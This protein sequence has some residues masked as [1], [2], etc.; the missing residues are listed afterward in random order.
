[1]TFGWT[2][3]LFSGWLLRKAFFESFVVT[4]GA[5]YVIYRPCRRWPNI[6]QRPSGDVRVGFIA[7]VGETGARK[8]YQ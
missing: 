5:S 1:M 6:Y 8:C 3:K 2:K 7:T 4:L